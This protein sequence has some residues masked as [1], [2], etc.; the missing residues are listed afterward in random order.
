MLLI[1]Y[2]NL[3][4]DFNKLHIINYLIIDLL[5]IRNNFFHHN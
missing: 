5:R 4:A 3:Y 2:L 1:I